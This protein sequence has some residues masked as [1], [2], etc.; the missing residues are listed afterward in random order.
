MRNV[1]LFWKALAVILAFTAIALIAIAF[2][3]TVN[4]ML[5]AGLG[6]IALGQIIM[7]VT[8]ERKKETEA[9]GIN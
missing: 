1:T 5:M 2:M 8:I 6:L 4:P 9:E 3:H 7:M